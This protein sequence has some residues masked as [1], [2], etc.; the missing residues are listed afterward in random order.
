M[1]RPLYYAGRLI[2]LGNDIE[3]NPG[4][5]HASFLTLNVG[6][7]YLRAQWGKL[8]QEITASEPII[9]CLQEVCFRRGTSHMAYTARACPKNVPLSFH[10]QSPDQIFPIHER[11]YKYCRLSHNRTQHAIAL[12]VSL[13]SVPDFLVVNQHGPFTVASRT[14]LDTWFASLAVP[15]VFSG[16]FNDAI[17]PN[18]PAPPTR[19]ARSTPDLSPV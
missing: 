6:G 18:P 7:L 15:A 19:W 11:L 10:D 8:L 14:E 3:M 9:I 4:P 2:L 12:E 1:H 5:Q 17:W 13:P 16:D